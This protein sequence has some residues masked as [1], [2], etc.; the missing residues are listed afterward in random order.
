MFGPEGRPQHS[1]AWLGVA[2]SFPECAS[3]VFPEEVYACRLII[4]Y[5]GSVL[6][7]YLKL[8]TNI[9]LY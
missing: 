8:S 3:A 5:G 6:I 4:C 9:P 2:S 1:C 7:Q